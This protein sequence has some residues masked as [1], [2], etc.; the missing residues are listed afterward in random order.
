VTLHN[1][2]KCREIEILARKE[3]KTR[4]SARESEEGENKKTRLSIDLKNTTLRK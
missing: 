3:G 2:F 4:H 1:N